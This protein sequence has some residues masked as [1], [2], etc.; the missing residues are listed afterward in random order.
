MEEFHVQEVPLFNH[1]LP[2][3][4]TLE[5]LQK[6]SDKENFRMQME[7][8]KIYDYDALFTLLT[9]KRLTNLLKDSPVDGSNIG[10]IGDR[11]VEKVENRIRDI[12]PKKNNISKAFK[13]LLFSPLEVL[14]KFI[15]R[16]VTTSSE[17]SNKILSEGL[18]HLTS[19]ENAEKIMKSGYIKSSDYFSSY[20][21]KKS[22]FFIG[23]PDLQKVAMNLSGFQMKRVA[24][25]IHVSKEQL[26]H[27]VYRKFSEQ[28]VASYGDFYFENQNAEIVYL[29]LQEEKENLVYKEI[30]KEKFDHY[31]PNIPSNKVSFV[32][33]RLK[34]L[35][36]GMSGEYNTL[37]NTMDTIKN[38][39]KKKDAT[40]E[41][42]MQHIF[43]LAQEMMNEKNTIH[44]H[45]SS[46]RENDLQ[47]NYRALENFIAKKE[48]VAYD[49]LQKELFLS[50]GKSPSF[51]LEMS[52]ILEEQPK[53][54]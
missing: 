17:I 33:N 30:S 47:Q 10:E 53:V 2:E 36:A 40:Y 21:A 7:D 28:A 50:T 23:E 42:N 44:N 9:N 4:I 38:Y 26:S 5:D 34:N 49:N 6:V 48:D 31:A 43:A 12:F 3:N 52:D 19:L 8:G 29:G 14:L 35:L 45:F 22:F 46:V 16:K 11:M 1:L 20:G 32:V 13:G 39:V 27:F 15:Y 54:K 24:V 37:L 51:D 25:K 41:E 18:Y